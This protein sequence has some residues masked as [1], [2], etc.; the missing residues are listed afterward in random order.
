MF[1]SHEYLFIMNKKPDLLLVKRIT[2]DFRLS[3]PMKNE[4]RS[5][6][7]SGNCD[8]SHKVVYDIRKQTPASLIRAHPSLDAALLPLQSNSLMYCAV[9][10]IASK[11]LV[12]LMIYTYVRDIIDYPSNNLTNI[13]GNRTRAEQRI[14]IPKLIE[15]LRKV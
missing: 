5:R 12:S 3:I 11:T 2:I 15:Q 13:D 9:P 10:K 1:Q 14:N 7:L 8:H 6:T 4:I